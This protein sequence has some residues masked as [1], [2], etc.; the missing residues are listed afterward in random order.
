MSGACGFCRTKLI[1]GNYYMPENR[2]GRR[3]ADRMFGYIHPCSTF[4]RSDM[5]IMLP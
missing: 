1:S 4:P 2:D 5:E 3:E